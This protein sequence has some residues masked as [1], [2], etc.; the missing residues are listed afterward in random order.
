M[1]AK[2]QVQDI[3]IFITGIDMPS[4][5]DTIYRDELFKI[6]EEFLDEADMQILSTLLAQTTIEVKV[7]NAQTT[8]FKFNI[9]SPQGNSISRPLFTLYFNRALQR[10][11]DEMQK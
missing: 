1:A 10:I 3:A 6:V 11:K 7:E 5:F 4:A 9:A 2:T 8:T